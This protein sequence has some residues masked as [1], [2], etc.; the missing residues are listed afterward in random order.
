MTNLS[1]S[2]NLQ[3]SSYRP[4]VARGEKGYLV[5]WI[6]EGE[7]IELHCVHYDENKNAQREH[8]I[9]TLDMDDEPYALF[10]IGGDR[11]LL[12]IEETIG[13]KIY[14][15]GQ[16]GE[17]IGCHYLSQQ[18]IIV[19][20]FRKESYYYLFTFEDGS[21]HICKTPIAEPNWSKM[22]TIVTHGW[23]IYSIPSVFDMGDSYCIAWLTAEDQLDYVY[24][25]YVYADGKMT[26]KTQSLGNFM[27]D[28]LLSAKVSPSEIAFSGYS[29]SERIFRTLYVKSEGNCLVETSNRYWKTHDYHNRSF[30]VSPLRNGFMLMTD[31]PEEGSQVCYQRFTRGNTF[32][33]FLKTADSD[34]VSPTSTP[35]FASGNGDGLLV[36]VKD[37]GDYSQICGK[38]ITISEIPELDS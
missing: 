25:P 15:L 19:N 27:V 2:E 29:S 30:Y 38:W 21:V 14:I 9:S 22:E 26:I 6:T 4:L 28:Y 13:N 7:T 16:T 10:Y 37:F 17:T 34:V 35:E 23:E 24:N 32:L 18:G 3:G 11:Y 5:V 12:A 33:H 31:G 36:Y 20:V 8:V 1:V